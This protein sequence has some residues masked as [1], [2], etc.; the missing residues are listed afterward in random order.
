MLNPKV[1][2]IVPVYNSEKYLEE[3]L[4]SL[5]NQTLK[6]IE[7]I[8]VDDGSTD[9]SPEILKLY[10]KVDERIK[11]ITQENKDVG[12]ARG[13]GLKIAKGEYIA[14]CDND[15]WLVMD[16][17]EKVYGTAKSNDS[18]I[19]IFKVVFYYQDTDSYYYP[20]SYDLKTYF[21][22]GIDFNN[23]TFKAIDIK[24]QV[25]N[26]AF[27]PWFKIYKSEFLNSYDFYFKENITYPDVP[28]HVQVLLR[29]KNISY[30]D[31]YL[32]YYRR[33]HPESTL[34]ISS[35]NDRI[36]DIFQ[37]IDE[38]DNFLLENNLKEDY[39]KEFSI[40]VLNQMNYWFNKSHPD[41]R[42][43]FYKLA[44]KYILNL[45]LSENEIS[46]LYKTQFDIYNNFIESK[47]SP[48]LELLNEVNLLN[49]NLKKA[50]SSINSQMNYYENELNCLKNKYT[51]SI[52]SNSKIK[53]DVKSIYN[54]K[55]YR[56]AY[57]LRR[58]SL[59]FL[60]GNSK[61]KKHFIKWIFYKL[62]GK[63]LD[64]KYNILYKIQK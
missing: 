51:K 49:Q 12:A 38:V 23:F 6:D 7:I 14:F 28:F 21:D 60:K 31:E 3:C 2:I 24:D 8:C 57:F 40:F 37:I 48:E 30:C 55:P 53:K 56:L 16:A 59:E 13:A 46:K 43:D 26:N 44:K 41:I 63:N 39:K 22:E 33:D 52:N 17:L 45:N 1:S 32:Y 5:I 18:D 9:S 25:L 4:D 61:D 11:I 36:F 27:A 35:K 34:L 64:H 29:A 54:S 20:P 10:S 19:S 62:K 47:T 42:E 50:S 58:F 15:D